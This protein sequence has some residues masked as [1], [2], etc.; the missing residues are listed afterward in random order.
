MARR[1]SGE[2]GAYIESGLS[3]PG[4]ERVAS[5]FH[6]DPETPWSS[7]AIFEVLGRWIPYEPRVNDRDVVH[8]FSKAAA[9]LRIAAL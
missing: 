6:S 1:K 7:L 5:W 4:A 3:K 9:A 8:K 2:N